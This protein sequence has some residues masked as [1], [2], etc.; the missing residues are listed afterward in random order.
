MPFGC[1]VRPTWIIRSQPLLTLFGRYGPPS[2]QRAKTGHAVVKLSTFYLFL[3]RKP[4]QKPL[5]ICSIL[6]GINLNTNNQ[7]TLH[8][9]SNCTHLASPP[10]QLGKSLELDCSNGGCPV[11][12]PRVTSYGDGFNKAG[13]GVFATQFAS[14]KWVVLFFGSVRIPLIICRIK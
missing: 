4:I 2:G 11:Q 6:E 10:N 14:D 5:P 8:T 3:C 9:D 12:D 7:I 13:G 1:S